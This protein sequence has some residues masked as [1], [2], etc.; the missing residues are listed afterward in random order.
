[1]RTGEIQED[2]SSILECQGLY[3]PVLGDDDEPTYT[4]RMPV[5]TDITEA[6]GCCRADWNELNVSPEII[7]RRLLQRRRSLFLL[8]PL[9][10]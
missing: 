6:E 5:I 4:H 8:L 3:R 10:L 7:L 2:P 1:M 9:V